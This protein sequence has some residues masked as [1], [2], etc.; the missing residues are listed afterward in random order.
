MKSTAQRVRKSKKLNLNMPYF[1]LARSKVLL[2]RSLGS[3]PEHLA[4]TH[5][6]LKRRLWSPSC[7]AAA[8]STSWCSQRRGGGWS[9]GTSLNLR[10]AVL[11]PVATFL[12][13]RVVTGGSMVRTRRN[14]T[15]GEKEC[16]RSPT[17][18][19]TLMVSHRNLAAFH[20]MGSCALW[21]LGKRTQIW[22]R[23]DCADNVM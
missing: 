5:A 18:F 11:I 23:V 8:A 13:Q 10:T 4:Q 9:F 16:A 22:R 2:K 12:L 6:W 21:E 3:W 1:L 19:W 14:W 20:L 15:P 17:P 7:S